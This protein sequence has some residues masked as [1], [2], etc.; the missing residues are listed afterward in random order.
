M[1][2]TMI[3]TRD[4]YNMLKEELDYLW[5]IKRPLITEKV[6]WAA[7]L[8]DRSENADY[9]Y[10]K[11]L[12][13]HIDSRVRYLKITMSNIKVADYRPDQEGTV[14]IGAYVEIENDDETRKLSFSIVGEDELF[15][16]SDVIT[17][18]SPMG[19][20]LLGK[21]VDDEAA[22]ET[23]GGTKY[24]YVSSISYRPRVKRRVSVGDYVD[25]ECRDEN[26][27]RTVLITENPADSSF[28][29]AIGPDSD[30][31]RAILGREERTLF[32]MKDGL[33]DEPWWIERIG[34]TPEPDKSEYLPTSRVS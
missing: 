32:T 19:K 28:E 7:S 34:K 20:A 22:V 14:Y 31:A 5:L 8:G 3:I 12:L 10:N 11:R 6:A 18:D 1:Y 33:K 15:G 25:L 27:N 9:Q 26:R 4:G 2:H 30:L 21:K 16:R 29:N 23:P 17:V 24:W 13:R